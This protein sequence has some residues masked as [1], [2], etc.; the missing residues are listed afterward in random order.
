MSQSTNLHLYLPTD[1]SD[2]IEARPMTGYQ[3]SVIAFGADERAEL[4]NAELCSTF[5]IVFIHGTPEQQIEKVI[6][7]LIDKLSDLR[8]RLL[9]EAAEKKVPA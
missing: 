8:A 2:L 3:C 4:S 9:R 6:D 7:P 1:R 5:V